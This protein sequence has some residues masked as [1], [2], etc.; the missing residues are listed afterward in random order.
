MTRWEMSHC[1]TNPCWTGPWCY[2][3]FE[4][5][6][7]DLMRKWVGCVNQEPSAYRTKSKGERTVFEMRLIWHSLWIMIMNAQLYNGI[8]IWNSKQSCC[9]EMNDLMFNCWVTS[10]ICA[11]GQLPHDQA[12]GKKWWIWEQSCPLKQGIHLSKPSYLV[13]WKI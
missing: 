4:S 12:V 7:A 13:Q 8:T 3:K 11:W 6:T 10:P 5:R 9:L 2:D 1:S